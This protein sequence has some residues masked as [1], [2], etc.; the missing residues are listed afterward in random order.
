LVIKLEENRYISAGKL[1]VTLFKQGTYLYVGRAKNNLFAR[2]NRHLR[3]GKKLFWHIDYLLQKA[4]IEEIWIKRNFLEECKIALEIKNS[5]KDSI[6][7]IKKFGSSD[8]NCVSHLFY[9]PEKTNFHSLFK[10]LAFERI[11]CGY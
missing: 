10:K 11:E 2:L 1:P 9:L 8:C 5:L 6:I 3:K 7:P 4:K